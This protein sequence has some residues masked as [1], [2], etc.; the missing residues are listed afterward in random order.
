[1]PL[2]PLEFS[3]IAHR[4]H[5]YCT[6]LNESRLS[7]LIE[8]LRLPAGA[9]VLDAGCGNAEL[10]VRL[11]QRYR[12]QGIGIDL[13]PHM[14]ERATLNAGRVASDLLQLR[15][16]DAR[17][18]NVT[19]GAL[20][21]AICLGATHIFGGYRG[22]LSALQPLVRPGGLLLLGELFVQ[23]EPDPQLLAELGSTRDQYLDYA[24][25]V[26]VGIDAGLIPLYTLTSS[27]DDWERYEWRYCW[28]IERWAD[29]HPDHPDVEAVRA[30]G[31]QA[32]D[33]YLRWG[34]NTWG[35]ALLLFRL[36]GTP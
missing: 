28:A 22:T 3:A 33:R 29:E 23:R 15:L 24:G 5:T 32:R 9:P 20:A 8:M 2:D 11:A 7:E 4:F 10:L 17:E 35:F 30:R 19:P 14:I 16:G 13:S 34:R 25:L 18:H 21:L 26:Q 36:P 1:M 6:P 27:T 12:V 31:R